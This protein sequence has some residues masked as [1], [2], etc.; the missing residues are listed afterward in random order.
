LVKQS[1]A[2]AR[3]ASLPRGTRSIDPLRNLPMLAGAAPVS[4]YRTLDRPVLEVLALAAQGPPENPTTAEA[5]AAT[6]AEVRI[7]DPFD[8]PPPDAGPIA[9]PALAGWLFGVPWVDS[10]EGRRFMR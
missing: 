7:F 1:T 3:L 4:A 10:P 9:D 2:L 6:G 5:L 8:T